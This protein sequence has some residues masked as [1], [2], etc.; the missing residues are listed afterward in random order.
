MALFVVIHIRCRFVDTLTTTQTI[1]WIQWNR[2]C[3]SNNFRLSSRDTHNTWTIYD[4]KVF[5]CHNSITVLSN[6]IPHL[7]V[8]I[9]YTHT[10]EKSEEKK[11]IFVAFGDHGLSTRNLTNNRIENIKQNASIAWPIFISFQIN[12]KNKNWLC[13]LK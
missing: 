12:L 8:V 7:N 3:Y 9:I 4:L 1:D 13:S 6:R 10:Q 11:E 2:L 5:A